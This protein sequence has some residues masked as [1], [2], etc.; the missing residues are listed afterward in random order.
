ME[1]VRADAVHVGFEQAGEPGEVP[2]AG[3]MADAGRVSDQFAH[4]SGAVA[5]VG[6]GEGVPDGVRDELAVADGGFRAGLPSGSGLAAEERGLFLGGAAWSGLPALPLFACG[7]RGHEQ[8]FR[9]LEPSGALLVA[10]FHQFAP[11]VL[12]HLADHV[13]VEVPD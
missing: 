10:G 4:L 2:A 5:L 7:A 13:L 3:S 12:A 11:E 6:Q 8:V 9:A 1:G